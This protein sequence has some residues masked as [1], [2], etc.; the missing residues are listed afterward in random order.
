MRVSGDRIPLRIQ[1]AV[2]GSALFSNTMPNMVWVALPLWVLTLD[3]S[4]FLIGVALGS[5]HIGPVL[6]SIHGGALMDRLGT[7]R[8]MLVFAFIGAAVPLLYPAMPWF[9]ALL[10][11]QLAGGMADAMGWIGAQTL[12]AQVMK[13]D[14]T[15][16]GRMSFCTRLGIFAG[17]PIIG[18]AWDLFGPWGA[19]SVMSAWSM[20]IFVSVLCLP[21]SAVPP[22]TAAE[23]RS[24]RIG[25]ADL[26]P[27]VAD[28]VAA[29]RLLGISAMAFVI[30]ITVLRHAGTGI[31]ESFYIVYLQGIGV[32]GTMIGLL[33]TMGGVF[34]LG[35]ALSVTPLLRVSRARWLLVATVAVAVIFVAITPMLGSMELLMLAS[36]LR[37]WAMAV[38]LVLIIS[39]IARSVE[40]A[41]QGKA[42]GLRVTANQMMSIV[43]PVTMG[44]L[45]EIVGIDASFYIVGGA[46]LVLIAAAGLWVRRSGTFD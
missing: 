21:A 23:G 45:V 5:R 11:L 10:V 6:F 31:Q 4:P 2:Y 27:K 36:G 32:S 37:G 20:G 35:G 7:R 22:P 19:F 38:S 34:G 25:F 46:A 16:T 24:G 8:V 13:G 41:A 15:Y 42:M 3:V 40:H 29:F 12:V 14:P 1:G 26:V 43:V 44:A 17:P 28:Y 33:L 9:G 39:L 18:A 30:V